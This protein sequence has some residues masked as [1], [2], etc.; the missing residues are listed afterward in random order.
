MSTRQ[1]MKYADQGRRP[2][3]YWGQCYA[4]T[5]AKFGKVSMQR[6]KKAT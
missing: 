4:E 3:K 6:G 1:M 2:L 5:I